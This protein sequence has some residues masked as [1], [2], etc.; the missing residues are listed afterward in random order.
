M[1]K[2]R[3]SCL[4]EPPVTLPTDLAGQPARIIRSISN[5]FYSTVTVFAR[6]L[7]LS[8]SLPSSTASLYAKS[9]SGGVSA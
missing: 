9:C 6:F 4:G 1:S 5:T 2:I 8:G 7:G 3:K